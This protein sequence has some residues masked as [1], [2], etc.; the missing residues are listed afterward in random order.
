MTSG[1]K[2]R[3]KTKTKNSSLQ[4]NKVFTS[5]TSQANFGLFPLFPGIKGIQA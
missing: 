5:F 3:C 1:N 2:W 4:K